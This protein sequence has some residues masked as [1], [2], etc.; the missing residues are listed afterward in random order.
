[1]LFLLSQEGFSE[2]VVPTETWIAGRRQPWESQVGRGFQAEK[3][4]RAK[5]LRWN[6]K[7][8]Q[9]AWGTETRPWQITASP[10]RQRGRGWGVRLESQRRLLAVRQAQ[11]ALVVLKQLV[12]WS[13]SLSVQTPRLHD[14]KQVTYTLGLCFLICKMGL[15]IVFFSQSPWELVRFSDQNSCPWGWAVLLATATHS[16][17]HSTKVNMYCLSIY[18]KYWPGTVLTRPAQQQ[19]HNRCSRHS[20]WQRLWPFP[21][22]Q[23]SS[24]FP[25]PLPWWQAH[26]LGHMVGA[27]QSPHAS[28]DMTEIIGSIF[29]DTTL[30]D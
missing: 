30:W 7:R 16:L 5:L 11:E 22:C 20:C 6:K 13:Q 8:D 3:T 24:G 17:I 29:S 2:E 1:M 15:I 18:N 27:A 19:V 28:L 21:L 4:P 23:V 10:V 25:L 14:V 26:H 9:R 12:H